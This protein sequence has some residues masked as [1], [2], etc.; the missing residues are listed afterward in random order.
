MPITTDDRK[1]LESI[2][3]GGPNRK[4]SG[5]EMACIARGIYSTILHARD[6]ELLPFPKLAVLGK[7]IFARV[8]WDQF[9]E[10]LKKELKVP[11]VRSAEEY[12]I[13]EILNAFAIVEPVAA[14]AVDGAE[15]ALDSVLSEETKV[16][17]ASPTEP[18]IDGSSVTEQ[19]GV[20]EGEVG[21]PGS[22]EEEAMLIDRAATEAALE[23]KAQKALED[24]QKAKEALSTPAVSTPPTAGPAVSTPPPTDSAV[25]SPP[26]AGPA[27]S[28]PPSAEPPSAE[29]PTAEPPTAEPPTAGPPTAGPPTAGPPTAGPPDENPIP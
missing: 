4:M 3:G 9:P 16:A 11:F 6:G 28:G 26:S 13:P 2:F 27:A 10:E 14:P 29:P 18:A 21:G 20:V 7:L 5:A 24:A 22:P 8:E 15:G 23:A 25:S 17:S 12:L 19:A 1:V